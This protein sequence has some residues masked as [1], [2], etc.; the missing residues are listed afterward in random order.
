METSRKLPLEQL[1]AAT[2]KPRRKTRENETLSTCSVS[3]TAARS[4]ASCPQSLPSRSL[5]SRPSVPSR[6]LS[7]RSSYAR[8][9]SRGVTRKVSFSEDNHT[10]YTVPKMASNRDEKEILWF[11]RSE[12]REMKSEMFQIAKLT[13]QEGIMNETAYFSYRGLE[14][15]LS[16]EDLS[17]IA[18]QSVLVHKDEAM[19]TLASARAVS[20]ARLLAQA[21]AKDAAAYLLESSSDLGSRRPVSPDIDQLKYNHNYEEN[22]SRSLVR[23]CS[24]TRKNSVRRVNEH[25]EQRNRNIVGDHQDN[26]IRSLPRQT[27]LT[28]KKSI[29]HVSRDADGSYQYVDPRTE[30][31]LSRSL[32]QPGSLARK[33]SIRVEESHLKHPIECSKKHSSRFI[34]VEAAPRDAAPQMTSRQSSSRRSVTVSHH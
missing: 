27:S 4:F 28:R 5:P 21:D 1:I 7:S 18:K 11:S 14:R 24:L 12:Y 34:T 10:T 19:Y 25:K 32:S 23:H 9:A 22:I 8:N 13:K 20:E 30:Y 16:D 29:R 33:Q 3:T 15:M 26:S 17:Q 6:S 31:G 2:K